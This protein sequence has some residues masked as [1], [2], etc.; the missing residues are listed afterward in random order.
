MCFVFI[1]HMT[2]KFIMIDAYYRK[3]IYYFDKAIEVAKSHG[4][5]NKIDSLLNK[6]YYY[7]SKRQN[8]KNLV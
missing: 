4:G 7:S 8:L 6:G 1:L 5:E 3:T 2:I